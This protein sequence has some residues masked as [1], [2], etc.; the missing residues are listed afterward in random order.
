MTQPARTAGHHRRAAHERPSD[1]HPRALRAAR[2]AR[3][4][5][6]VAVARL[7][8]RRGPRRHRR[9]HRRRLDRPDRLRPRL[10]D[11][12]LRQR[13]HHLALHRPP[14]VLPR[15]RAT[16]AEARRRP[17]LHPRAVRRRRV[18]PRRCIGGEHPDVSPVGIALAIGSII[19]M[20]ILGIAKQR[21][22]N[23]L[24]SAATAGEG[25]QNM[26][27]A[28]LAGALLVGLVGNALVG[29]WW[30][31]PTRR[32]AD[33]RRRRQGGRRG[34]ARRRLLRRLAARRRRL[35]RRLLPGRLLLR[36]TWLR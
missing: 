2:H 18:R 1:D 4:A 17:V 28:Y 20:P 23:Q 10:R 24:G 14:H 6:L 21:L 9:R 32:P 8:E 5:A 30:L 26:L 31:D 3:Q 12:G 11:R 15:R 35:H 22:A 29:A 33:R 16:R 19:F 27:C 7:D 36:L 34:L 13:D 25:R